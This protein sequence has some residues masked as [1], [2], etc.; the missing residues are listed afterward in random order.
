MQKVSRRQE[1][2]KELTLFLERCFIRCEV[3]KLELARRADVLLKPRFEI[4]R[5]AA[6]KRDAKTAIMISISERVSTRPK[7]YDLV[8]DHIVNQL[9]WSKKPRRHLPKALS[10]HT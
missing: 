6:D 9:E 8:I 2:M 4:R 5:R 7:P 10:V 1:E 3:T